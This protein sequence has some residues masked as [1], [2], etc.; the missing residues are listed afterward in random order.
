MNE[1]ALREM[2]TLCVHWP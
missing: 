1:K 2:Q